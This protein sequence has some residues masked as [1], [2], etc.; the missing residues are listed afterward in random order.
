MEQ[1]SFD[2]ISDSGLVSTAESWAYYKQNRLI[3]TEEKLVAA[4][5]QVGREM[6]NIG[7]GD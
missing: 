1:F 2:H 3:D 6:D 5:G 7:E 4:T